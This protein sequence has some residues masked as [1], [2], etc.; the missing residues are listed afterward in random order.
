M[1]AFNSAREVFPAVAVA[2]MLGFQKAA[3]FEI[4]NPTERDAPKVR[5]N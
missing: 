2:G 3:L 4:E 1:T 5:F